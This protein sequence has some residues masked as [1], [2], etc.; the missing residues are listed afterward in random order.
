MDIIKPMDDS[1]WDLKEG[2]IVVANY[3]WMYKN[4][5]MC[6]SF[7][8]EWQYG[9]RLQKLKDAVFMFPV[10]IGAVCAYKGEIGKI[11]FMVLDNVQTV[12]NIDDCYFNKETNTRWFKYDVTK[13][14]LNFDLVLKNLDTQINNLNTDLKEI[15]YLRKILDKDV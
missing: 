1:S 13:L 10:L 6:K 7:P 15:K 9:E 11:R 12:L 3:D 14:K 2:D 8:T 4:K 5:W